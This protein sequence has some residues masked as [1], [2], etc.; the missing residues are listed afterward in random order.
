M[1]PSL[2]SDHWIRWSILI[3]LVL[4]LGFVVRILTNEKRVPAPKTTVAGVSQFLGEGVPIAP[5]ASLSSFREA[6]EGR[7]DLQMDAGAAQ[8]GSFELTFGTDTRK[9]EALRMGIARVPYLYRSVQWSVGW[10]VAL[11]AVEHSSTLRL[12]KTEL[13]PGFSPSSISDSLGWAGWWHEWVGPDWSTRVQVTW[14][15]LWVAWTFA[16]VA[17]LAAANLLS[18]SRRQHRFAA[19]AAILVFVCVIVWPKWKVTTSSPMSL[20]LDQT[21]D[22]GMTLNELKEFAKTREGRREFATRIDHLAAERFRFS[23]NA[24]MTT[25]PIRPTFKDVVVKGKPLLAEIPA[26]AV[27][28]FYFYRDELPVFEESVERK[29]WYLETVFRYAYRCTRQTTVPTSFSLGK[30]GDASL[31]LSRPDGF[32]TYSFWVTRLAIELGTMLAIPAGI[33]LVRSAWLRTTE[34]RR[35][36]TGACQICGYDLKKPGLVPANA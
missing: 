3:S 34:R 10:P 1:A 18:R 17:F 11:V 23:P 36:K 21:I 5:G 8:E 22:T 24:Q 31:V 12:E 15:A 6:A 9:S 27:P 14:A 30:W 19:L 13:K 20:S 25:A 29:S 4:L 35:T 28:V 33:L 7:G 2:F 26:G 16:G 32:T